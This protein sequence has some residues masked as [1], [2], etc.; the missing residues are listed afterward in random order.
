[1]VPAVPILVWM[2]CTTLVAELRLPM[3]KA[4]PTTVVLPSLT[5]VTFTVP[6][7]ALVPLSASSAVGGMPLAA[8]VGVTLGAVIVKPTPA[9]LLSVTGMQVLRVLGVVVALQ[10]AGTMATRLSDD[11]AMP[12]AVQ[13]SAVLEPIG[14]LT[15]ARYC[16]VVEWLLMEPAKALAMVC[17]V[18]AVLVPVVAA[19]V[20]VSSEVLLESLTTM[21]LMFIDAV[22]T[23]APTARSEERRVGKE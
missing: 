22:D 9:R 8:G 12:S 15:Q 23:D 6:L 11:S 5:V 10:M 2:V 13:F 20:P 1:M 17:W 3:L 14:S 16:S 19:I 4:V 7:L 18:G 21:L